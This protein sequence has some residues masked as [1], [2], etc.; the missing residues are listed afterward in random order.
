MQTAEALVEGA[1]DTVP[2]VIDHSLG[3]PGAFV[4]DAAVAWTNWETLG[5][6]GVMRHLV[7]E[8]EALPG[9]A[10]PADAARALVYSM[11]ASAETGPGLHVFVT[12]DLLVTATVAR[13]LRKP[14]ARANW[15]DYLEGAFFWQTARGIHAAYRGD[16]CV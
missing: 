9:M 7:E 13:F 6:E 2:V 11:L 8:T 12:H 16:E 15:P 3:D 5:H 1:S 14:F 4:V 10:R